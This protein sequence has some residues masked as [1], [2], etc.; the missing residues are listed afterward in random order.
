MGLPKAGNIEVH[1][2]CYSMLSCQPYKLTYLYF[3]TATDF[4]IKDSDSTISE[5][6]MVEKETMND[7]EMKS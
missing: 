4:E 7:N 1:D 3:P 2:N 6:G 5:E